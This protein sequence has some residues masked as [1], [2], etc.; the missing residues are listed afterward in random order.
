MPANLDQA[1]AFVLKHHRHHETVFR[2]KFSLAAC[3]PT[4]AVR[5]VAIVSNPV[6]RKLDDGWTLEVRRLCSD[7]AKNACSLLYAAC[8][9]AARE[10]GYRRMLTYVLAS[11]TGNTLKA[12]GWKQVALTTP[13]QI[14][15]HT[16]PG[17][18]LPNV[19]IK[20]RFE[21][22]VQGDYPE[23]IWQSGGPT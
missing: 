18:G 22:R 12:A 4:G 20:R 9:R 23:P 11:E 21:V 6:S 8:W 14:Q 15:W 7:G 16:R 10:L 13:H 5:A 1:N 2:H 17:R 19:Q 3:D